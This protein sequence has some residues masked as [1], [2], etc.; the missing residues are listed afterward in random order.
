MEITQKDVLYIDEDLIVVNKPEDLPIHKN[1]FMAVDADYL[2]KLVGMHTQ[3]PVFP[4]HRRNNF[5]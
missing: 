5:V 4:V 1:E 2:T 3:K